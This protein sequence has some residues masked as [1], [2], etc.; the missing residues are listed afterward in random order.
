MSAASCF[1]CC[2]SESLIVIRKLSRKEHKK[3]I[4]ARSFERRGRE[5]GLID[6]T[7]D[8]TSIEHSKHV[9]LT[10]SLKIANLNVKKNVLGQQHS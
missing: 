9:N 7:S 8:F 1:K 10:I 2:Q 5:V 6:S 3:I 4:F